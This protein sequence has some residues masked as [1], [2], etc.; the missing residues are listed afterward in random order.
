MS[1]AAW[2]APDAGTHAGIERALAGLM[3]DPHNPWC[4]YAV[5]KQLT[6]AGRF[7]GMNARSARDL[8]HSVCRGAPAQTVERGWQEFEASDWWA[9]RSG[10]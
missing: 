3:S 4:A 8:L 2:P 9:R 7:A 1:L 6:L 5:A 10:F